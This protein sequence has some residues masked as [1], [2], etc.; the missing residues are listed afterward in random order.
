MCPYKNPAAARA[1]LHMWIMEQRAVI[2]IEIHWQQRSH[3]SH[4]ASH[5]FQSAAWEGLTSTW[6]PQNE[7]PSQKRRKP[8]N[9]WAASITGTKML[10]S[11]QPLKPDLD[12]HGCHLFIVKRALLASSKLQL[13]S[14]LNL[15]RPKFD[16]L[17][18]QITPEWLEWQHSTAKPGDGG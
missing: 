1:S 11:H 10:L 5:W 3:K 8:T 13:C 4:A 12:K 15:S 17:K 18:L 7:E 14:N 6:L 16:V 2:N 9:D